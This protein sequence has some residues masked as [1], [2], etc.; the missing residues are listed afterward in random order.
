MPATRISPDLEMHYLVDDYTDPWREAETVLM[1]HGNGENNAAWFAWVPT[2]ARR[3]RVVRPDMRGFGAS[4]PMPRDYPWSIDGLI[5][6]YVRLMETLGIARCHLVGSKLGGTI[7]RCFAARRPEYVRTLTLAGTPPPRR[8][9]AAR[10]SAW[11]VEFEQQGIEHWARRTTAGRLGSRFPPAGVEWW[12][13]MMGRTPVSSQIGFTQKIL[14]TDI[15][16]DLPRIACPTLV[17]TTEDSA[18]ET[19]AETRAWQQKIPRSTLLVLPG[20]SFH[21]A[22]SDP[23][24][25]ARETLDFISR[26]G[27]VTA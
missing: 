4:T 3:F 13:K 27:V 22:A 7:A 16:A 15:T 12:I 23:D 14:T 5:D 6:D 9:L 10:V 26:A 8:D 21:V 19:V 2:L 20:D 24:R 11:T 18:L 25:C 17:I 1:L